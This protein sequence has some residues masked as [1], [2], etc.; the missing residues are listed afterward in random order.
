MKGPLAWLGLLVL[1]TSLNAAQENVLR[2]DASQSLGTISPYVYGSNLG[3]QSVIPPSLMPQA[4]ALGLNYVRYGGGDSDR[5]RLL[6]TTVD[7]FIY[8]V[9]QLGAEPA[10]TVRLLG[11]TPEHA[12]NMV[13]YTNI[14]KDYDI[15]YWSIGNEPNIYQDTMGV[16]YTTEDLNRDW[17]DIAEAMLAVDP[18]I[19]LVGPDITQYVVLSVEA[20]NIQYLER[21]HCGHPRDREG[22]DWLQE[23][24]RA[25]GDLVDIVSIHRYP[26]PGAGG[27]G[28]S[29]ATIDGLRMN[30]REWDTIIPNLRQIIR[31]AAGRDIPIAV[32]EVNSNS[33]NSSG[34]EASLDSLY[35]AVWFGD[36]LGR[37]IRHQVE[38][39]AY[40]DLQGPI[41][42]SWG[43]LT[44][45]GVRPTYYL[46]VMYS[47]FGTELLASESTDPDVSIYAARRDD[48]ML[49]VMV[50]NLG[51]EERSLS[52]ELIGFMPS[53]PAEVWRFDAEHN[54]EQI[55]AEEIRERGMVTV[56]GQSMTL[57]AVPGQQTDWG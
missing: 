45:T 52:L 36:V 49:T 6:E 39:V 9:R 27:R 25:N 19:I 1:T 32:T 55:G 7:L 5:R 13:R 47:H 3:Q 21:A 11:G 14:E 18:D 50:V 53:E 51:P 10:L 17:R 40:W 26:Y 30:S 34:G 24:L 22:R 20:D 43:L 57:Y 4:Q 12:A 46:Y 42:R 31:D 29:R 48:G 38:I 41:N 56:P 35:N 2:V 54:A 16:P 23:F 15:R 28:D 37:L 8:Q 44:S 33:S